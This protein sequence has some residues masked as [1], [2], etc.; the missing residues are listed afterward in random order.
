MCNDNSRID[1]NT[2]IINNR[3]LKGD[4][5][6]IDV[7][8]PQISKLT[9]PGQFVHIKIPQLDHRILRRPFSIFNVEPEKGVLSVVYKVVGDGTQRLSSL[10]SDTNISIIG[11]LGNGF[12]KSCELRTPVIVAGGYGCAATYL[13]A[14]RSAVKPIVLIGGRSKDDL[15]LLEEFAALGCDVR[16]STDDGSAGHHGL[17]TALLDDILVNK[18]SDIDV[19]ACGPTPMLMAVGNM[20]LAANL[21]AELSLDEAMCCGVGACFAC[22]IKQKADNDDG[23]KYVRSCA[24]GPVFKASTIYWD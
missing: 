18:K 22:V 8:A 4:Y 2:T 6:Q 21:D 1:E 20:M 19:F 7:F 14:K 15:L 17:V 23:W 9:Q 16:T 24:E 5:Y 10:G 12:S 3:Q 13:V 11:P